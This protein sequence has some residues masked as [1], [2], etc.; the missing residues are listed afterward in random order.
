MPYKEKIIYP[1][2]KKKSG[3][4][5]SLFGEKTV[6]ELDDFASFS[7]LASFPLFIQS[8]PDLMVNE[9][10]NFSLKEETDFADIEIGLSTINHINSANVPDGTGVGF[11]FKL[12]LLCDNRLSDQR[13][14]EIQVKIS[15]SQIKDRT[16]KAH[17]QVFLET[18][19]DSS[20]DLVLEQFMDRREKIF[21]DWLHT[22]YLRCRPL[23][24]DPYRF[25]E[26][27]KMARR[28]SIGTRIL[29]REDRQPVDEIRNSS[30][31]IL[32][33]WYKLDML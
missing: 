20:Q 17:I 30:M 19:H 33:E 2:E 9:K 16:S 7:T 11:F 14:F 12:P 26:S 27:V 13:R 25:F 24:E 28:I 10:T 15:V 1:F 3:V 31:R 6:E 23:F 5:F 32:R 8:Y 21:F 18:S 29:M 22:A 4:Q